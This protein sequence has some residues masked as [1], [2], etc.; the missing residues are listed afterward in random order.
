MRTGDCHTSKLDTKQILRRDISWG[1]IDREIIITASLPGGLVLQPIA[2]IMGE[3]C[4]TLTESHS[5]E[6]A[7]PYIL[8]LVAIMCLDIVAMF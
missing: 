2:F 7:W 5:Q 8:V 3:T 6:A 4:H 1:K